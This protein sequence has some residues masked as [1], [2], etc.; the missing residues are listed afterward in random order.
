MVIHQKSN[1]HKSR[2][3]KN[4][5]ANRQKQQR[6]QNYQ[7]F[8][9]TFVRIFFLFSLLFLRLLQCFFLLKQMYTFIKGMRVFLNFVRTSKWTEGSYKPQNKKEF[10]N[11]V[12][13]PVKESQ[14]NQKYTIINTLMPYVCVCVFAKRIAPK[15]K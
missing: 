3:E 12:I 6:K 2:E 9:C 13:E 4:V 8:V 14:L 1:I 10:T 15:M 11:Q 5:S 7:F